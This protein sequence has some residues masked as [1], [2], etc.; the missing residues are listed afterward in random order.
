MTLSATL[1]L[2]CIILPTWT[3]YW[4]LWDMF[5]CLPSWTR[6]RDGVGGGGGGGGGGGLENLEVI[7]KPSS[8]NPQLNPASLPPL[9]PRSRVHV[10]FDT[11]FTPV[12]IMVSFHT[13]AYHGFYFMP[14]CIA[15]S[16]HICA[17]HSFISHLGVSRH[18][19]PLSHS[20]PLTW[21]FSFA[22]PCLLAVDIS[23][24]PFPGLL[25]CDAVSHPKLNMPSSVYYV[26]WQFKL[27]L[28]VQA[29]T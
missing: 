21:P 17:Y 23:S 5:W 16:F 12:C 4:S 9:H 18:A 8:F 27:V 13:Y 19:V 7:T 24:V 20:L 11:S 15:V 14:V 1:A 22:S 26:F 3:S 28:K 2:Y 25:S 10:M 6:E 29:G